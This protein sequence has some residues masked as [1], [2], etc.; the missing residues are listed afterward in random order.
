MVTFSTAKISKTQVV[1]RNMLQANTVLAPEITSVSL[2]IGLHLLFLFNLIVTTVSI[3]MLA[4][5]ITTTGV[6]MLI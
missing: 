4:N 6:T 2:F 3:I 1:P 5:I